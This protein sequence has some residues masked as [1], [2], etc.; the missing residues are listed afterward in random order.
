MNS[1]RMV[2]W[3]PKDKVSISLPYFLGLVQTGSAVVSDGTVT[4]RAPNGE[5]MTYRIKY[6]SAGYVQLVRPPMTEIDLA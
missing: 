5:D 1:A 6:L 3:A 4:F 2:I